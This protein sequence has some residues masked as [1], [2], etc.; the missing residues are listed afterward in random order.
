MS[1]TV[2]RGSRVA[3]MR[4]WHEQV[5]A[6]RLMMFIVAAMVSTSLLWGERVVA[7]NGLGWDGRTY[8]ALVRDIDTMIRGGALSTYYAQRVLP[9]LMVR[10]V[11]QM[12][13]AAFSDRNIVTAFAVFNGLLAL[14][15]VDVWRRIADTIDLP[16]KGRWIGFTALF[17]NFAFSKQNLFYPVLTDTSALLLSMLLLL[18]HLQRNRLAL[19]MTSIVGSFC[20]PTIAITGVILIFFLPDA[21]RTAARGSPADAPAAQH[22]YTIPIPWAVA[23]AILG[24]AILLQQSAAHAACVSTG[25]DTEALTLIS[26]SAGEGL[27]RNQL[28]ADACGLCQ[29]V[30]TALPSLLL[31]VAANWILARPLLNGMSRRDVLSRYRMSCVAYAA[32]VLLVSVLGVRAI[33]NPAVPNP[34]SIPLLAKLVLL[35]APGKIFL[36]F[37]SAVVFWGPAVI[38]AMLLWPKLSAHARDLGAGIVIALC[39]TLPFGL[40]GEPRF[41]TTIWP[42]LALL[43]ALTL[44]SGYRAVVYAVVV[45]ASG[46]L[47]QFWLPINLI[48][49]RGGDFD[50]IMEFPKQLYFM[51]YG[52]WMG[53]PGY[54]LQ[55]V[56][57]VAIA[58]LLLYGLRKRRD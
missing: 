22:E 46:V 52:L 1:G 37:V 18:F 57:A 24:I 40:V 27:A 50:G 13:G 11:L 12:L 38:V 31:V 48:A 23:S 6:H 16:V 32:V 49:W 36:P 56:L 41:L 15:C 2:S 3:S 44:E 5:A 33:A 9:A 42:I 8:A 10:G 17:V 53:W 26:R 34:S 28:F 20:W 55:L 43:V 19:A 54:V 47:A 45:V 29:Q 21:S 30:A 25:I 58:S 35:P 7:G 39:F 14:I 51:H 4:A